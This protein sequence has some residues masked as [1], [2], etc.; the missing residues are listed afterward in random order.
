MAS[1][2][3]PSG[4]VRE[5]SVIGDPSSSR[6]RVGCAFHI[7]LNGG[8]SWENVSGNIGNIGP[9]AMFTTP[10]V[11]AWAGVTGMM[12]GSNV[13]EAWLA[14]SKSYTLPQKK[15]KKISGWDTAR[16]VMRPSLHLR[17]HA[18]SEACLCLRAQ[19]TGAAA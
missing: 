3:P 12:S 17:P 7:G 2:D 13:G 8:P 14:F 18:C 11:A 9:A 5:R 16:E 10:T 4:H 15:C 19:T 6:V 1:V